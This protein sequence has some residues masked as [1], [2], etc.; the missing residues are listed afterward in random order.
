MAPAQGVDMI[1]MMNFIGRER[2]R[3]GKEGRDG[4]EERKEK[5]KD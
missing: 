5:T 1:F 4:Q 3:R 2:E